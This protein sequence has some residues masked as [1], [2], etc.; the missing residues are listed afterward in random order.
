MLYEVKMSKD[1]TVFSGGCTIHVTANS[2]YEAEREAKKKRP[3][4]L[5]VSLKPVK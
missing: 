4:L 2:V 5:I 3:D 1:G